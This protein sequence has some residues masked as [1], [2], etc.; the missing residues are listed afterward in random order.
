MASN[1]DIERFLARM[2]MN[3][4]F[5]RVSGIFRSLTSFPCYEAFSAPKGARKCLSPTTPSFC[6]FGVN[7]FWYF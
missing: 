4:V 7:G 5:T 6:L 2:S 3:L 1:L